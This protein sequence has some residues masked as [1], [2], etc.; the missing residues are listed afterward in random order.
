MDLLGQHCADQHQGNVQMVEARDGHFL[1]TVSAVFDVEY[2][3]NFG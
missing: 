3:V 2:I 1:V